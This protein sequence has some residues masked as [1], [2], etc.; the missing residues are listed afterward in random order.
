[1]ARAVAGALHGAG[2]RSGIIVT[3]NED[4]G[5][6]V[7]EIYGHTWQPEPGEVRAALLINA[8]PIGMAGGPE[9]VALVFPPAL[10]DGAEVVLDVVALPPETPLVRY[11]RTQGKVVITGAGVIALQAAEQFALYTGTRPTD[12]R[13]DPPGFGLRTLLSGRPLVSPATTTKP[14]RVTPMWRTPSL[15]CLGEFSVPCLSP[16]AS[17]SHG[18]VP[19]ALPMTMRRRLDIH[20]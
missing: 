1:M 7:A 15:S 10:I 14:S 18:R 3:R 8:T 5:R 16:G 12:R 9:S 2:F 4:T 11:V 13:T 6:R 19:E 20:P 17:L